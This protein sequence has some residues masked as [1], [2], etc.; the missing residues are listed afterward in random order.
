MHE[1]TRADRDEYI[2]I[3]WDNIRPGFRPNFDKC[4]NCDN[5]ETEYDYGSVMH[6][7]EYIFSR[8]GRKTIE[9]KDGELIRPPYALSQL[10][11]IGINKHYTCGNIMGPECF[12][13]YFGLIK[14]LVF[15]ISG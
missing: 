3:N 2:T 14:T 7:S 9:A 4:L 10:D 6:Y 5:Q 12:S 11:I 8:N 13:P 1:H 15:N